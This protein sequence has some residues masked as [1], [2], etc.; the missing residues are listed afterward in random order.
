MKFSKVVIAFALLLTLSTLSAVSTY[1]ATYYIYNGNISSGWSSYGT[2]N[3]SS[4][5]GYSGGMYWYYGNGNNATGSSGALWSKDVTGNYEYAVYITSCN[6]TASV[7]YY[8]W[9]ENGRRADLNVNQLNYSNEWVILGTYR[10]DEY[11][12]ESIGMDNSYASTSSKVAWD[13]ARIRN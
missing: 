12:K 9:Y 11:S 8:V 4:S 1:A 6:A 7:K 13:E 2:M 3:T 5:C 10:G